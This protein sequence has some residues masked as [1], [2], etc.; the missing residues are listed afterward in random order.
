MKQLALSL[1]SIAFVSILAIGATSAYFTDQSTATGNTFAAGRLD[2]DLNNK[3]SLTQT[4]VVADIAPGDRELAGRVVLKNDGSVDGRVWLEITNVRTSNNRA[5]ANLVRASFKLDSRHHD[6]T[7]GGTYSIN[8]A[9]G[10]RVDL[11]DLDAQESQTL[12]VYAIWPNG[13]PAVDNPAQ[14]GTATFDV[15]FHLDQK[16]H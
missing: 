8:A 1:V 13:S 5:F 6:S 10:R 4:F 9:Q 16:M 15:V 7:F 12:A 2:L 14:G 3:D 11:F